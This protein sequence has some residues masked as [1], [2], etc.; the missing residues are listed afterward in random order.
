MSRFL[1]VL[2]IAAAALAL[3]APVGADLTTDLLFQTRIDDLIAWDPEF[4]ALIGAEPNSHRTE[5]ADYDVAGSLKTTAANGDWQHVRVAGHSNFDA[6]AAKGEVQV[7]FD[8]AVL[9]ALAGTRSANLHGEIVCQSVN[10]GV[11]NDARILARLRE[12]LGN[13]THLSLHIQDFGNPGDLNGLVLDR[14]EINFH[15]APVGCGAN[16]VS[17][18]GETHGNMI[19]LDR[20]KHFHP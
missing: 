14:A 20:N 19:V 15:A 9:G 4:A 16:G 6:F 17:L 5:V 12:P 7:S 1:T 8:S 2:T 11:P 10:G 3:T 18:V 13:I